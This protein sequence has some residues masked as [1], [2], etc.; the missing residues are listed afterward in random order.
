LRPSLRAGTPRC[1]PAL[2]NWR[3]WLSPCMR[4]S[5]LCYFGRSAFLQSTV[6]AVLR[7]RMTLEAQSERSPSVFAFERVL[8]VLMEDVHQARVTRLPLCDG[9]SQTACTVLKGLWILAEYE[10]FDIPQQLGGRKLCTPYQQVG[11][12]AAECGGSTQRRSPPSLG[13][14]S[15]RSARDVGRPSAKL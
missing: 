6:R 7:S 8:I 5:Q 1:P 3:G 13:E 10:G 2:R 14:G 15:S 4:S 9:E 12:P 11:G